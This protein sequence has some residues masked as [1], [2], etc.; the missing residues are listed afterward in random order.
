M[1]KHIRLWLVFGVTVLAAIALAACGASSATGTPAPTATPGSGTQVSA[2]PH[3]KVGQHATID[4]V[5]L[6]TVNDV[7]S[8][9]GVTQGS[10]ELTSLAMGPGRGPSRPAS[11][12]P[13]VRSGSTG[14]GYM[15]PGVGPGAPELGHMG[16]GAG[17]ADH[18]ESNHMYLMLEIAL[19]NISAQ[20]Q[21]APSLS[22]FTLWDTARQRCAPT[23]AGASPHVMVPPGGTIQG[24]AQ[25][26]APTAMRHF[27]Y[28]F[29]APHM[30]D[31]QA[32][33]DID[34]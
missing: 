12:S 21:T 27:T 24:F 10:T 9:V 4:N 29:T 11:M 28:M 16:P 34:L 18:P 15:S 26:E 23:F 6:I 13:A 33:W 31:G 30:S 1:K 5:W 22:Q 32:I 17:W 3:L 2:S 7:Q 14:P 19:K 8:A 20:A 25:Y